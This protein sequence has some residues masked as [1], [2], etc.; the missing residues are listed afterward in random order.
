MKQAVR[1]TLTALLLTIV[2][3]AGSAFAQS[4]T[5]I[6]V[7]IPF[8]FSFGDQTFPAGNYSL[9]QPAQH[10][11]ALRDDR[12]R[13]IASS[14]TRAVESFTTAP[15]SKLMFRSVDGQKVLVQVWPH[16]NTAGEELPNSTN[17]N[18]SSYLAKHR[19]LDAGGGRQ[20]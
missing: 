12:A 2:T 13:V 3:A 19:S 5:V 18:T 11:L 8:D 4:G 1:H 16:D 20:P 14:F 17:R 7:N 10:F 15:S 6:K 9:V